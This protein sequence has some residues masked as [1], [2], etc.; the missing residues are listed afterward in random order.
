[1]G[2]RLLKTGEDAQAAAAVA[3]GLSLSCG[4]QSLE[5]IRRGR[6]RDRRDR[7]RHDQGSTDRRP[8]AGPAREHR[9]A[10]IEPV[11]RRG[12]D[13]GAAQS[14]T[15]IARLVAR[16]D[17]GGTTSVWW[18]SCSWATKT[19]TPGWSSRVTP[20]PIADITLDADYCVWENA[21]R[22]LRRGLWADRHWVAPW[23][24]RISQRDSLFFVSDYSNASAA[25]CIREI[26]QSIGFDE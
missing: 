11:R 23:D 3:C 26:S 13:A 9:R 6:G 7:R 17:T 20:G 5:T 12:C 2:M 21:A 24:W 16:R 4:A 18:R 1:M 8:R 25:G 14:D 22:S 19:S 15:G 10:G